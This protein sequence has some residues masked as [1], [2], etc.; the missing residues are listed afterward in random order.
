M[1]E[2]NKKP[3]SVSFLH[4]L[5]FVAWSFIGIR[6]KKGY[7]DDLS[8]VNPIHVVMV[9]FVTVVLVVIG[10]IGLVNWVVAK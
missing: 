8:K 7:Q 10:L 9:G 3:A 6:S 4:S 5:K 1:D 2:N